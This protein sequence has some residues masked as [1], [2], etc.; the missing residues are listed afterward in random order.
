MSKLK[1]I[2]SA[3]QSDINKDLHAAELKCTVLNVFIIII[4]IIIIIINLL[5]NLFIYLCSY[6]DLLLNQT[7]V[8]QINKYSKPR[9]NYSKITVLIWS[10]IA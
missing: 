1:G 9:V 8:I 6:F 7:S 10:Y 2:V 5:E 3:A 4:I